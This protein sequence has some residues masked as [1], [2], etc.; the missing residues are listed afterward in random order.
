MRAGIGQVL[1]EPKRSLKNPVKILR[2][3]HTLGK[4][5]ATPGTLLPRIGRTE[6][7]IVQDSPVITFVMRQHQLACHA[8]YVHRPKGKTRDVV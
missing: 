6:G 7:F 3:F 2:N 4:S 5:P 1:A 8:D